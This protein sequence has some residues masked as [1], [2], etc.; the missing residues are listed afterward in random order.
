VKNLTCLLVFL[1]PATAG[2]QHHH[3]HHHGH[4]DD[5][6][7]AAALPA[8]ATPP[9]SPLPP[10]SAPPPPT[11]V[12][13]APPLPAAPPPPV[14]AD[15]PPPVYAELPLLVVTLPPRTFALEFGPVL[16]VDLP[17][18]ALGVGPDLGV[19]VGGRIA[20]GRG[21][22]AF[23]VRATWQRYAMAQSG[24]APCS[25]SGRGG[26]NAN[27]APEVPCVSGPASGTYSYALSEDLV[28]VSLPLS[29]RFFSAARAFNAYVGVAP[30]LVLQRA[31]TTA[32]NNLTTET[33]TRFGVGGFLGGQYRLGPGALWLE[34]G[35]AWSPVSHRVT[36]DSAI[37][38]VN[39]ALG[40]RF[41][42]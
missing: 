42:L 9:A 16:G 35:Y 28:R 8:A 13:V 14:V 17:T 26:S 1:V 11:V 40:Y 32:W 7:A 12:T 37:S 6:P 36:G 20:L 3:R 29:Y 22:V 5:P 4:A 23:A 2:A 10:A 30:Q 38:T 27:V 39:L 15:P 31:E 19:E 33:A 34:A 41:T 25:P 18:H 21:V 24:A